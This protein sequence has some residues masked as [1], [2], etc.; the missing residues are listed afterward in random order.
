MRKDLSLSGSLFSLSHCSYLHVVLLSSAF[1][2]VLTG[3]LLLLILVLRDD[4]LNGLK[5]RQ[6][7]KR[8]RNERRTR[9]VSSSIV[10]GSVFLSSYILMLLNCATQRGVVILITSL[11]AILK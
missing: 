10:S 1:V 3:E 5:K 2:T 8:E 4:A 7:T 6:E 9:S 11:H